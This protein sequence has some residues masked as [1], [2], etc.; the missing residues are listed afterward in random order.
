MKVVF[1]CD[2]ATD[3]QDIAGYYDSL[4]LVQVGDHIISVIEYAINLRA[5]PGFH[6]AAPYHAD[7]DTYQLTVPTFPYVVSYRVEKTFIDVIGISHTARSPDT[8]RHP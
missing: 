5:Q 7:D 3:L 8:R 1:R 4:G 6:R 2:A